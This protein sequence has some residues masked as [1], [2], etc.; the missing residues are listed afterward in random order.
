TLGL[1][2]V[3]VFVIANVIGSGVYKKVAPMMGELHSPGWVL[4][5]WVLGGIITLFGALSYA[6]VAG[7]L[8]D[9]G[10]DYV[11]YKKIYN[12][13][14]AFQFGWSTFTI[15]QTG[16]ISSLAYVFAQSLHSVVHFPPMLTSL[17]DF[18]IGG[19]FYPL[20]DFNIKFA[21][22]AIIILLTIINSR[23]LK[24]GAWLSTTILLLVFIG[25][26]ILIGFGLTSNE[27]NISTA[28][29]MTPT[30][31]QHVTFSILFT[32]ML[33]AF[34]AYQGWASIG[35]IAGEAK[36]ANRN[37]PIGIATGMSVIIVLYLLVNIAYLSL[38]PAQTL[39]EIN[40]SGNSIA[41]VEA[42]KIFWG[43][44]GE[45]FIGIL[46]VITTLGC[47]HATIVT[48]SRIYYAM[49][50]EGMFFKKASELNKASVPG[51][52]LLYQ[53][54]W[55]CILVLSGTFDQLTDMVIF[56][57]FFFYGATA[58]GVFILR[59]K[60]PDAPRPYKVWGYPVVPAIVILFSAT[61]FIN[62]IIA[63]PR[64]A[65]IGLVLMLTGVPMYFY[66]RKRYLNPKLENSDAETN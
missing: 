56:A 63:R 16:A 50:K 28:F 57:I 43:R 1:K 3:I 48:S 53:C 51:N 52:S 60:M 34:W 8:A 13:F 47:D 45:I 35:Y 37:I 40:V 21:A 30:N 6:E 20:K 24:T 4:I 41:A 59:K 9:T 38:I 11:Y 17:S 7:L 14:F 44:S 25:I 29:S 15:I 27:S 2:L 33:A 5:A 46:I 66:F 12:K 19:I 61:L 18:N 36:N 55:A 54:I 22:M 64:E 23:G 31:H 10:G 62:T 49:A 26:F 39:E 65:G 42:V 58:L 32:A